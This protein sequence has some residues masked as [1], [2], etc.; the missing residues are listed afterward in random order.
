MKIIPY[1]T[2]NSFRKA[3]IAR[4]VELQA[5]SKNCPNVVRFKEQFTVEDMVCIV[6]E[7]M[8]GGDLQ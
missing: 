1:A 8:A 2:F 7:N 4:E 5:R 3:Q 6:M